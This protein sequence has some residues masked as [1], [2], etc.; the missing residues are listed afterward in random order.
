MQKKQI[1]EMK[2]LPVDS[3]ETLT[4]IADFCYN[5]ILEVTRLR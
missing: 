5:K 3:A 2:K 4:K 1:E